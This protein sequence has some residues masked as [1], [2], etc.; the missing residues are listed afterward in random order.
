MSV[1]KIVANVASYVITHWVATIVI[2]KMATDWI[3]MVSIVVV[4]FLHDKCK[5]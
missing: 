5:E 1:T 3:L 4:S 2:V